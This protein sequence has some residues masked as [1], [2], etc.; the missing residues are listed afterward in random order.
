LETT[1]STYKTANNNQLLIMIGSSALTLGAI[2]A[3]SMLLFSLLGLQISIS[4]NVTGALQHYAAGLLLCT[5]AT[6]LVPEMDAA[7][8]VGMNIAVLLGFFGGVLLMISLGIL[9]PEGDDDDE[10]SDDDVP[11]QHQQQHRHHGERRA[12]LVGSLNKGLRQRSTGYIAMAQKSCVLSNS[13]VGERSSLLIPGEE[14][15][16]SKYPSVLVSAIAIDGFVDGLLI[17]I[18]T[19]AA[20]SSSAGLM[21]AASLSVEMTFLG[22][23]LAV[24][25]KGQKHMVSTLS[26]LVGPAA[27]LMGAVLGGLLASALSHNPIYLVAL[28]SFG[29]SALLYMVAE[30]L[31]FE[32]HDDDED[33]EHVWWVDLQLYVGFYSSIIMGKVLK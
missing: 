17:G 2:P 22:I 7:E 8:G 11:Q 1:I 27:I 12:S 4:K 25:L 33:D 10:D 31:L 16:S 19:A 3:A 23:T 29:T 18:T 30:E 32:A 28:L 9:L 20:S 6:E 5:I 15:K 13:V 14:K 26:S 24:A 21:M